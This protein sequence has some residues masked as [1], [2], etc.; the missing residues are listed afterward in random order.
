MKKTAIFKDP[1]F[2]EHDPGFTHVER[3]DRLEV[4]YDELHKPAYKD[5][6]LYPSFEPASYEILKYNH[7]PALIERIAKTSGKTFDSLDPDTQT[8]PRSYEAACMAAG[9]CVKGVEMIFAGEIDNG[10]ALVRPPGHHAE[11][12]QAMGFCLFN[13]IAI[14]AH[15]ALNNLKAQ[16]VVIMD[17]DLHHGNGTQHSFYDTDQVLYI[18]THQ[19]PYYPGTGA[20]SEFGRG[21]GQGYTLNIPLSGGQGDGAYVQI[22]D[23]IVAPV[24]RQYNPDLILVSAGFDTYIEDPLGGMAVTAKGFG[25][26][27]RILIDLANECCDGRILFVLEGGYNLQGLRDGVAAVLNELSGTGSAD[28]TLNPLRNNMASLP[29]LEHVRKFA[30]DFWIL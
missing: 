13:N 8:S 29:G 2:L 23:Q 4:I 27:G 11:A 10:F 28:K 9:A 1:I 6:F 3:P 30:K 20:I 15:Y 22:F 26:L 12:D 7:T 18:S 14:A 24:I 16:R 17:W 19:Y 5:R 21:K 25:C